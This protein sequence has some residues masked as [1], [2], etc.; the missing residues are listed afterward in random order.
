MGTSMDQAPRRTESDSPVDVASWA[1]D[2]AVPRVSWGHDP[3]ADAELRLRTERTRSMI[4][5]ARLQLF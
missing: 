5:K 2:E 4:E 3:Y 1:R